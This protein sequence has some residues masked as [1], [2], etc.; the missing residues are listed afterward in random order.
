[1]ITFNALFDPMPGE[2]TG[3]KLPADGGELGKVYLA[4][5]RKDRNKGKMSIAE[6]RKSAPAGEL[7][8]MSDNELKALRDLALA[9]TPE[10]PKVRGGYVSGD[11]GI[12]NITATFD[13]QEQYG[14]IE[15][16]KK[17]GV[18]TVV[19]STWSDTPPDEK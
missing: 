5:N 13:K 2:K 1:M 9:M 12:L 15:M 10:N 17:D 7:D 4:E 6:M 16:E 18:W 8:N 3:E 11:R 19:N 14:T